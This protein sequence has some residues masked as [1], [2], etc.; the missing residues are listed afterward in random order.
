[1][2][3]KHIDRPE[4]VACRPT[5]PRQL[6]ACGCIGGRGRSVGGRS[7]LVTQA[8]S[9]ASA[10][11]ADRM[12]ADLP[13]NP[14]RRGE[15]VRSPSA[16][17]EADRKAGDPDSSAEDR[18]GQGVLAGVD[19]LLG[20][21]DKQLVEVLPAKGARGHL[22]GRHFEPL[23]QHAGGAIAVDGATVGD[24][25]PHATVSV[26]RQDLVTRDRGS[27]HHRLPLRRRQ[28]P[29]GRERQE[30]PDPDV[31]RRFSAGDV[32]TVVDHRFCPLVGQVLA[33][34]AYVSGR[35]I[36]R[37]QRSLRSELASSTNSARI[38]AAAR[39]MSGLWLSVLTRRRR[40]SAGAECAADGYDT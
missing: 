31:A 22:V 38:T 21:G 36:G 28:A 11:I 35:G 37:H 23:L 10:V 26:D 40:H 14:F 39:G 6:N 34:T 1:M 15:T 19:V 16:G 32:Q 30:S 20:G 25:G 13:G 4:P 12:P 33:P 3:I 8:G 29:H 18:S 7:E 5:S 2:R 27:H 9:G 17:E 24:R